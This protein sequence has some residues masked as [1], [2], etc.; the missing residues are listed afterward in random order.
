VEVTAGTPTVA[1]DL[2]PG[3]VI[4]SLGGYAVTAADG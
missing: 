3:D 4:V 2:I 1:A